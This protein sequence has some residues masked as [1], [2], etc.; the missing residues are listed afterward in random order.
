[1]GLRKRDNHSITRPWICAGTK[2]GLDVDDGQ[3][4]ASSPDSSFDCVE[5]KCPPEPDVVARLDRAVVARSIA[6][7]PRRRQTVR[8]AAGR[9]L[10]CCLQA[11]QSAAEKREECWWQ[12]LAPRLAKVGGGT[13]PRRIVRERRRRLWWCR[14]GRS[15]RARRRA[16][17][18]EESSNLIS[19]N[20]ALN[21]LHKKLT[22]WM[23]HT[24][25]RTRGGGHSACPVCGGESNRSV[26]WSKSY[27][28]RR[29]FSQFLYQSFRG[30][31]LSHCF[32]LL[33]SFFGTLFLAVL[34]S[35]RVSAHAHKREAHGVLQ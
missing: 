16:A 31:P 17:A 28:F 21:N 3:S 35:A 5:V 4:S 2:R 13:V 1:M 24:H 10:L 32:V 15:R 8:P 29:S 25:T 20:H 18:T 12:E 11:R 19:L 23:N 6:A 33:A 27:E 34:G 9:L 26:E 14:W 7:M 22:A 30:S